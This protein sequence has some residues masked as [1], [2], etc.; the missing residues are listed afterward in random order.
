MLWVF[1]TILFIQIAVWVGSSPSFDDT[2]KGIFWTVFGIVA[3]VLIVIAAFV[4]R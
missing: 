3:F 4:V 1:L 2:I